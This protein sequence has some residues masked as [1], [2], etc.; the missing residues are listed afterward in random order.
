MG[1]QLADVGLGRSTSETVAQVGD[2]GESVA[3]TAL[4]AVQL[5]QVSTIKRRGRS[6][7]HPYQF[8]LV[9][10]RPPT[11]VLAQLAERPLPGIAVAERGESYLVLSPISRR[12]YGAD[13]AVGAGI[14]IVL[15]VLILTAITPVFVALL[16][17]ALLPALPILLDHRPDLAVSALIEDGGV[18][19]VTAHGE[20]TPELAAAL[21]AYLGALPRPAAPPLVVAAARAQKGRA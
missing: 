14:G 16:P 20:A 8:S 17:L 9:T 6:R 18:T 13:I 10:G 12:R 1:L 7:A 3:G 2:A 4:L 11:E 19:R 5:A 15:L 21:D